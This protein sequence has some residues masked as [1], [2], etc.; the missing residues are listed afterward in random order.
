MP[1]RVMLMGLGPIGAAVARQVA[2]RAGLKIVAAVD[3]D[4]AK[5]GKDAGDVVGLGRK[6][7]VTVVADAAA[8]LRKTR[9]QVAVLCTS[10]SLA[11]VFPQFEAVLKAKVPIVSTTEELA[12]PWRS[13]RALARRLDAVARKAKAAVVGTGVNPGFAMDAL[14]IT[15]TG[16]C[17]RV[18]RVRVD[19]VQDARIRRLPFQKKIG[20]GMTP[21]QFAQKVREG[22]VRHVGL[23]E[24]VAMIADA[25][26]WTLERITD[27]IA[28]KIAEQPVASEFLR[29]ERGQ[30]CGI[31]QDGTGHRGGEPVIVLHMEAYLGAPETYDAIAITGV[32]NLEVK[33]LGGFHGDVATAAITVNTI[34]KVLEAPPGLHTMRSLPIPSFFGGKVARSRAKTRPRR[35][36]A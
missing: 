7:G 30:V 33:A 21:E 18:D 6:L 31:V 19:R 34:P 2:A 15:L 10:S 14:P 13:H 27:E 35:R 8:A 22:T 29:V 3:I 28:P 11:K 16:I 4:P 23:T 36:A 5:V 24:S 17:E 32:P 20:A 12:Y 26:G 9:P 25:L 1:I